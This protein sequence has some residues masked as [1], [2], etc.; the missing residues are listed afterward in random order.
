MLSAAIAVCVA[1]AAAL[2]QGPYRPNMD[3]PPNWQQ[4]PGGTRPYQPK[5]PVLANNPFLQKNQGRQPNSVGPHGILPPE[6]RVSGTIDQGPSGNS[7]PAQIP[8]EVVRQLTTPVVPKIDLPYAP[9]KLPGTAAAQQPP[10]AVFPWQFWGWVAAGIFVLSLLA[11]LL[12]DYVARKQTARGSEK[13][14]P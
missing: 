1:H 3:I 7:N 8:P 6:P 5:G 4:G 14:P 11:R 10:P 9:P 2:A 12:H 13:G